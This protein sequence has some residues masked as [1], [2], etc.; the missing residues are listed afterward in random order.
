MKTTIP[1]GVWPTMITPFTEDG[2]I[3]FDALAHL[4]EWYIDRDV[5]GLF[6]VCQ[7][8]EMFFLT[9]DERVA[10]A[11]AVVE[12]VDDRVGVIASGHI[13]D[14]PEDQ[15]REVERIAATG[16]EAVVLVTNRLALEGDPDD[17]WKRNLEQL[18]RQIPDD[19]PLGFYECPHPYKRLLTPELMAWCAAT[20]RFI[21]L[22]DTSCD[23]DQI[24]EKLA[25]AGD[26]KLYNANA[27]TLLGSLQ[28]G[29]A[30]YSSVMG[31]IHPELYAWLCRTW[32][33]APTAA[34]RLQDFLGVASMLGAR[35]YP[36]CAK[37][38][39]QLEGLP[40][41]LHTRTRPAADLTPSIKLEVAQLRALTCE[42]REA[43]L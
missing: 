12:L 35:A 30:G 36:V 24:R 32:A 23:P 8:S 38:Y 42:Y 27:A 31:N 7:S 28:D 43:Y 21:F 11:R 26:I 37:Y 10:L 40:I 15:V 2:K 16:V 1:D 19:V 14:R 17:A 4:V 20:G 3:D 13:S 9:L 5:A 29:A 41:S 39:L 22:K 25:V 34:A 33:E 18:L 6:A